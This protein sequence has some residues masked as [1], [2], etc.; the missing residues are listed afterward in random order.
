MNRYPTQTTVREEAKVP[1]RSHL[2]MA[3]S[4]GA[5]GAISAVK[6]RAGLPAPLLS[7]L[8]QD[9]A[10]EDREKVVGPRREWREID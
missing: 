7:R 6:S 2:R 1:G 5:G 9:G 10:G 4:V 8:C 3:D